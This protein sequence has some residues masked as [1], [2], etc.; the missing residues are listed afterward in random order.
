MEAKFD[1]SYLEIHCLNLYKLCISVLQSL[2]F[3]FPPF[4]FDSFFKLYMLQCFTP[5][6]KLFYT[7]K[8]VF[9]MTHIKNHT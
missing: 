6:S 2:R 8:L 7:K 4:L 1:L 5:F 3:F 9:P